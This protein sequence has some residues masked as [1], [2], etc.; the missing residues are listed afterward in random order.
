MGGEIDGLNVQCGGTSNYVC[1]RWLEPNGEGQPTLVEREFFEMFYI[2]L[3]RTRYGWGVGESGGVY[4]SGTQPGSTWTVEVPRFFFAETSI[5]F[6]D[7]PFGTYTTTYGGNDTE[8]SG[9]M[10]Y[11]VSISSGLCENNFTIEP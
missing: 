5:P 11:D 9:P 3:T 10:S 2:G 1:A 6:S 4:H 7:S 8:Y